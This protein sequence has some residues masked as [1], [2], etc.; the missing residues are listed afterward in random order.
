MI[1]NLKRIV[2]SLVILAAAVL[3]NY[4]AGLYV[5]HTPVAV[6]S[7][8]ILDNIPVVNLSIIYFYGYAFVI[9]VFFAIAFMD[10]KRFP[11][12]LTQFSVLVMLR[13]FFISLTHLGTPA[14]AVALKAP[15]L[16]HLLVFTNDLFF[17]GHT[18]VPFLGYLLF[19][20]QKAGTFFL[21]AT[22]VLA[23][24]VLLMHRHYSIDVFAAFFITYGSYKGCRLICERLGL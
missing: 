5:E 1:A 2:L 14:N 17:S 4:V 3:I 6:A 10:L 22:I 8:L 9:A 12:I 21:I 16:F 24:T 23:S 7:D 19:R 11:E 20:K 13:S 15:Y 18:A